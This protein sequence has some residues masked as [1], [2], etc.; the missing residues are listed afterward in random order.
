MSKN[1]SVQATATDSKKI[2]DAIVKDAT[3]KNA[4]VKDAT[5]KDEKKVKEKKVKDDKNVPVKPTKE[6]I[7]E[8]EVVLD[9]VKIND[10]VYYLDKFGAIWSN[11]GK[12]L[13][14]TD[15]KTGQHH[16][17]DKEYNLNKDINFFMK[18]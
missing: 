11:D 3:V 17:F 10:K 15:K 16:F 18:Q 12:L 9:E 2:K 13:G 8:S 14:S 6:G 5:V 7:D 1:N 4:T